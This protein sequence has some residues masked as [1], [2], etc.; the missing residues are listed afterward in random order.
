MEE[1]I[2]FVLVGAAA[3]LVDGALGM[4]Y[5]VVCSSVLIASGIPPAQASAS[6]HAAELFTTAA[7]G[8]SHAFHRNIDW[9]LFWRLVP[10]GVAGGV[11]GAYLLTGIDGA[12]IKPWIA[13]Y[14]GII[15]VYLTIRSF[16]KIPQQGVRG[17]VVAPLAAVGG[18]LDAVGGGGWGPV[19][20]SGLLGAGGQPR[21][22]V[23]TVN[24]A[25]F[26][27]TVAVSLAFIGALVT[28]RWSDADLAGNGLA[29]GG[30]I[31]GG[32]AAA[33]FAGYAVRLIPEKPLLRLVGL[34]IC[35]LS[36][37]QLV[38]VLA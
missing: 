29:V 35:T 14:L 11:A 5:G 32:L 4:A 28:G 18:F 6:I 23:G 12:A 20:S 15:G 9:R 36:A 17:P 21:Y 8:G 25:E 19:V 27:V 30:L 13:G 16:R 7:S 38:S 22:V 37:Y 2:I 3:Q 34:L 10:F 33:P 24:A 31:I 1:F 26:L